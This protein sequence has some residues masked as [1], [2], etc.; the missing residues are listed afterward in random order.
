[1]NEERIFRYTVSELIEILRS[2]P[3]ETP[4]LT[5]GYENGFENIQQPILQ[6]LEYIPDNPDYDG[7]F[8]PAREDDS[9]VFQAVILRRV[10]RNSEIP[11]QLGTWTQDNL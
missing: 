7:A 9:E 5:S 8:Q 3:P 11:P 4:I 10:E 2:F 6:S 1:M